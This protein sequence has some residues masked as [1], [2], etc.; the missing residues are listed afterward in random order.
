[1]TRSIQGQAVPQWDI[2]DRLRKSLRESDIG[3]QEM[4]DHLGVS[5]NTVS[6][7]I[8]GRG[9]VNPECLPEW[10]ALTGFP[11]AWLEH[12]DTTGPLPPRPPGAV[13]R[14]HPKAR[15]I[16][17]RGFAETQEHRAELVGVS[18]EAAWYV[19]VAETEVVNP[20]LTPRWPTGSGGP[21]GAQQSGSTP[22]PRVDSNHQPFGQ[23]AA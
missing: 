11:Q 21:A 17:L 6:S 8:N 23:L 10:A 13:F 16:P 12:G 5:R 19:T 4:A 3:V 14:R 7:W 22:L 1:M 2:A 18:D 20:L 9:P 15:V